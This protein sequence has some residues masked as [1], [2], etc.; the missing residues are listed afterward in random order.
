M[1]LPGVDEFSTW[2][3]IYFYIFARTYIYYIYII[4][5]FLSR[6]ACIHNSSPQTARTNLAV[7]H[8]VLSQS[9]FLS[10][11]SHSLSLC[12]FLSFL[13]PSPLTPD[14]SLTFDFS[15]FPYIRSTPL[16]SSWDYV[17]EKL[18][19]PSSRRDGTSGNPKVC[20]PLS[21]SPVIDV[22]VSPIDELGL[23]PPRGRFAPPN[24]CL[25]KYTSHRE[26]PFWIFY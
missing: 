5:T 21:S 19:F 15:P 16:T 8:A 18:S 24:C 7:V 9:L 11:F 1:L 26:V 13:P 20:A 14:I 2:A 6:T 25:V 22:Y 23:F 3:H 4:Y 17:S 10:I 12:L